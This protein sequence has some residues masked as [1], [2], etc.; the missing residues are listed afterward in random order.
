MNEA[1]KTNA[2]PC[3][4]VD[5]RVQG[6]GVGYVNFF[7]CRPRAVVI[8]F[9]NDIFGFR[10]EDSAGLGG[11]NVLSFVIEHTQNFIRSEKAAAS[12]VSLKNM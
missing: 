1:D 4:S 2:V 8:K 6:I 3:P 10:S 9:G 11:V 5:Y 12:C 7:G